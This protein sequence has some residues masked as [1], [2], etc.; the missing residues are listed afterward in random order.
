MK[1]YKEVMF[2]SAHFI[3]NHEGKCKHMHGHTY[4]LIV[5]LKGLPNEMDMIIDYGRLKQ[6]IET[7]IIQQF[8]HKTINDFIPNPT[9]EMMARFI[10]L[11]LLKNHEIGHLVDK[12]ILYETPT[13]W[14]E[15]DADDEFLNKDWE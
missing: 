8:D 15:I 7:E 11:K 3:P 2:D 12:V 1:I 5:G 4:K 9:A 14:V 10:I 13:S 6:I